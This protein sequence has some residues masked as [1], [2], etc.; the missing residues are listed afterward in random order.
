M[1]EKSNVTKLIHEAIDCSGDEGYSKAINLLTKA[2]SIQPNN[3]QA[4]FERGMAY[5]ELDKDTDAIADFD[6][7]LNINPEYSGARDWRAV[8]L[9]ALGQFGAAAE[10]QYKNLRY[11]PDGEYGMGVNPQSW[12]DCADS[13][14]SS[15][16][17]TKA[18]ELLSEYFSVHSTKVEKYASY[19]TAPMRALSK[20]L[21]QSGEFESAV[22]FGKKAYNS[23]HKRPADILVYA[24]ALEAYGALED[25]K[26]IAEEAMNINDQMSG[27][28]ELHQRLAG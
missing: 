1:N 28:K 25:A 17:H 4:Y 7:A 2:I 9:K 10:D 21:V 5:L 20:L 8:A 24:L 27:V 12:A 13:F 15:G 11:N 16:N 19:E 3:E 14:V 18:R 6:R 23:K 22:E 26:K